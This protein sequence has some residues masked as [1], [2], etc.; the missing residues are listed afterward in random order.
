MY[1]Q[2][3]WVDEQVINSW[4]TH[5][6]SISFSTVFFTLIS[7]GNGQTVTSMSTGVN[8]TNTFTVI[9]GSR[10]GVIYLAIGK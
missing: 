3:G 6:F 1:S 10:G 8:T 2:W 4:G 5:Y 7:S 9:T